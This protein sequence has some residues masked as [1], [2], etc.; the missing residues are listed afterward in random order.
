[1]L[2]HV[3]RTIFI[4]LGIDFEKWMVKW[5]AASWGGLLMASK[6]LMNIKNSNSLG[7]LIN[8]CIFPKLKE[9]NS[10]NASS[11]ILGMKLDRWWGELFSLVNPW[12]KITEVK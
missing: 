11:S 10:L 7:I 5:K 6:Y 1:M 9:R 12:W 2:R 4:K 3:H 8:Y